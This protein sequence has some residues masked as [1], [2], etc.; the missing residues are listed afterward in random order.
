MKK[1]ILISG[2]ARAGKDATGD[3]IMKHLKNEKSIKIP[4]AKDLKEICKNYFGWDGTKSE[5]GRDLLQKIGT[6]YIRDEL[7]WQNFH[8][9]RVYED[10]KIAYNQFDRFVICDL[11]RKNEAYYLK[12]MYPDE[13]T[14]IRIERLNFESQLTNEQLNH[15]SETDLDNFIFDYNIRSES[16]LNNL[17]T[18]VLKVLFNRKHT[19][20]PSE[21][22]FDPPMK[23]I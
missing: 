17:E 14:T 18:E 16:G 6:N 12:A 11:R 10:I 3:I 8:I 23:I 9:N 20:Q 13:V 22:E 21:P 4:I 5:Q 19:T 2:M 7:G 1:I 15:I